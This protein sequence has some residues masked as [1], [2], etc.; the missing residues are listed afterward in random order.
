M[1]LLMVFLVAALASVA[2]ARVR[3]VADTDRDGDWMA[4]KA[5]YQ[6]VYEDAEEDTL[7]RGIWQEK[8]RT[9]GHHNLAHSLGEKSFTLEVNQF[10]DMTTEEY[11]S[12]LRSSL[13]RQKSTRTYAPNR[14]SSVALAGNLE[15]PAS[16]DWRQDG[17]VTPVKNQGEISD[18][19]EF[20]VTGA[21]EG[22]WFKKSGHLISL[23]EQQITDCIGVADPSLDQIY[24]YIE[25][26]GIESDTDYPPSEE[27]QSCAYNPAKR[28]AAVS[29]FDT[30]TP[31][32]NETVLQTYVATVGPISVYVDASQDSFQLYSN[33]VYDETKCSSANLDHAML[34]VGYGT[35]QQT[36]LDYWIVK[37]SW[38]PDWGMGGYIWMSR[39][40]ENQC[41]IATSAT[42]PFFTCDQ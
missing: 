5:K 42:Y 31:A 25:A 8:L 12:L 26:K 10:T 16:V 40:K 22:Q 29:G 3:R 2:T 30:I 14:C 33:G 39:N 21:L 13:K 27:Q 23:S 38:G 7:R 24:K 19:I 1:K 11:S 41:G 28:A 4:W 32:G 17:Y 34:V 20:S 9:I 37:N 6:K 15:L 35:D 18:S 36:G